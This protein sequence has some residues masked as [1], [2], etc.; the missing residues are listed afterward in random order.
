MRPGGGGVAVIVSSSLSE[1]RTCSFR[2]V[3]ALN[4]TEWTGLRAGRSELCAVAAMKRATDGGICERSG[5]FKT[6]NAVGSNIDSET[7]EGA[8]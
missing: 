5:S 3:S 8:V 6:N 7:R 4:G 1:G 2:V